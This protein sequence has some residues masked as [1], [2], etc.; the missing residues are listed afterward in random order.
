MALMAADSLGDGQL[1]TA[2]RLRAE[3]R[4]G[5]MPGLLGSD[6][7]ASSETGS[8]LGCPKQREQNTNAVKEQD[9]RES[10]GDLR[11]FETR[12]PVFRLSRPALPE[13]TKI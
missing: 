13:L 11:L 5:A 12:R 6:T 8:S 3:K 1:A 4:G 10:F 2:I 9:V 7:V